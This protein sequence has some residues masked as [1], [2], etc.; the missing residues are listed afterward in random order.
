[1]A[2][3]FALVACAPP[4]PPAA[5]DAAPVEPSE[6]PVV[7]PAVAPPTP[8]PAPRYP[9]PEAPGD[10]VAWDEYHHV[11]NQHKHP[12]PD[13]PTAG[14]DLSVR[15]VDGCLLVVASESDGRG[16]RESREEP[17]AGSRFDDGGDVAPRVRDA[18]SHGEVGEGEIDRILSRMHECPGGYRVLVRRVP[19]ADAGSP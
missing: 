9:L 3:V 17:F 8:P 18:L 15:K 12:M 19:S 13:G 10:A 2:L 6:P 7:S 1:M 11:D 5:V 4:T 16:F 14:W